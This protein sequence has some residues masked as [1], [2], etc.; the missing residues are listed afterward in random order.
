MSKTSFAMILPVLFYE[1]LAISI[2]RSLIPSMVINAFGNRSYIAVGIMET[3]KGLL[4]FIR[5]K[6]V[7][8][9]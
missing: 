6:T 5:Y 2:T 1:Y 9:L 4:A 3:V 8:V 7:L